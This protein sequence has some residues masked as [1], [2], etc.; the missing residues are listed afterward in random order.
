VLAFRV[1]GGDS[2]EAVTALRRRLRVPNGWRGGLR[3]CPGLGGASVSIIACVASDDPSSASVRRVADGSVHDI[4]R[5]I[6]RIMCASP[7]RAGGVAIARRC[8]VLA[9]RDDDAGER[10][11]HGDDDV[12]MYEGHSL[13]LLMRPPP[14]AP[15]QRG[16]RT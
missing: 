8:R 11:N 2:A 14:R 13:S 7:G 5:T 3:M 16:P 9:C 4:A 15:E 10:D 1:V 6:M 12:G